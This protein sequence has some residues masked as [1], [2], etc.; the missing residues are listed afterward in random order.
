MV[1]PCKE[2]RSS[3]W[4]YGIMKEEGKKECDQKKNWKK[5]MIRDP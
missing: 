2:K 4:A 3:N 1:S 5:E